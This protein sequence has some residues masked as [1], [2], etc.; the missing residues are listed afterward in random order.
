[1]ENPKNL[2][3]IY[4]IKDTESVEFIYEYDIKMAMKAA[5]KHLIGEKNV[6]EKIR[7]RLKS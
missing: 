4:E 7:F 2:R 3:L 5:N 1:M 6:L